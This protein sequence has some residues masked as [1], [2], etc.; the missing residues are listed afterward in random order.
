[1]RVYDPRI[2]RFLSVAPQPKNYESPYMAF[3]NNP[4]WIL[5]PNGAD[6][7]FIIKMERKIGL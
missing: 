6:S 1:M 4:I 2:G 3:A 5:D 7:I